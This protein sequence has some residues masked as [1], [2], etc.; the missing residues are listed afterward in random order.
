MVSQPACANSVVEW[1]SEIER[2]YRE[3]DELVEAV[4]NFKNKRD[5][6][7]R[8]ESEICRGRKRTVE[9]REFWRQ[10]CIADSRLDEAIAK[11]TGGE[12]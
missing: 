8:N 4:A 1:F 10:L 9:D 5:E 7:D 2:V 11:A 3:R 12:S 6:Y